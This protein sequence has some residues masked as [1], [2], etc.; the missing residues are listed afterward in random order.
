[1]WFN[2]IISRL[3]NSPFHGFI[4]KNMMLMT[5]TGRKSGKAYS[6]PMNYLRIR[7][8][9]GEMLYTQS[10]RDRHW[11]RNLRNGATVNIHLQ[12]KNYSAVAEVVE[13]ERQ[14][15]REL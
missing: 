3:L 7:N 5:Y 13:D 10:Y 6:L 15:A 14:V 2:P 12:G 1:M 11:W 8:G 9:D 4:S